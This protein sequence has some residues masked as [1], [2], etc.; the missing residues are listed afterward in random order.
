VTSDS[1][2]NSVLTDQ[3][4]DHEQQKLEQL[5][6][7]LLA[8]Q[9]ETIAELQQ[10]L[11]ALETR[12]SDVK[13]R[14]LDSSEVLA[15][16]VTTARKADDELGVALKPIVVD[17]FHETSRNDPELMAEALFPILGPAVRKMIFNIISPEKKT[18]KVGYQVE[19]LFVI[20]KATG[21]PMC[22]VASD[23]AQTQDAD[24][25]SG[26]LSAIQSFVQDAFET[27][28]FDGLN[29]LR[30]TKDAARCLTNQN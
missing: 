17:Q 24:M 12:I 29:T 22:H 2:K 15:K 3:A 6:A 1:Q 16:A 18:K 27:D 25:V 8:P 20:D 23:E 5:R 9:A 4:V 13:S 14:T 11:Q 7:V 30:A 21:L 19:Q 10:Q 26:M 28:E